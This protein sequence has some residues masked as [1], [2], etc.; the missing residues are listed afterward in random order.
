MVKERDE[1]LSDDSEGEEGPSSTRSGRSDAGCRFHS[2]VYALSY[3][4][5]SRRD[6]VLGVRGQRGRYPSI[7]FSWVNEAGSFVYIAYSRDSSLCTVRLFQAGQCFEVVA[8]G[9]IHIHVDVLSFRY[10]G[11]VLSEPIAV[12]IAAIDHEYHI[13]WCSLN[14]LRELLSFRYFF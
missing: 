6:A 3:D 12:S 8:V 9:V 2:A 7:I 1:L 11:R 14:V 10:I 5:Y 4:I 13:T